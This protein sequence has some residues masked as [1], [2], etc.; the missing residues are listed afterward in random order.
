MGRTTDRRSGAPRKPLSTADLVAQDPRAENV[1]AAVAILKESL[2]RGSEIWKHQF[3]FSE[4]PA[5]QNYDYEATTELL[6]DYLALAKNHVRQLRVREANGEFDNVETVSGAERAERRQ[7][8]MESLA[9]ESV[10]T[11]ELSL[12]AVQRLR[13]SPTESELNAPTEIEIAPEQ[14]LEEA[15]L[16]V[17]QGGADDAAAVASSDNPSGTLWDKKVAFIL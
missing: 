15:D 10:V 8:R 14:L 7:K 1:F 16:G 5:V 9:K 12:D 13:G 3:P 2:A 4:Y 11:A 6:S 17:G